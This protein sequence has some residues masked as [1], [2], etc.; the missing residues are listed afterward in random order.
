MFDKIFIIPPVRKLIV[1]NYV[2]SYEVLNQLLD[3][4]YKEHIQVNQLEQVLSLTRAWTL[5]RFVESGVLCIAPC[6][7]CHGKFVVHS[8]EI[9]S[10]HVCGLCNVPSRA[11]KTKK[12]AL[13][14]F[15]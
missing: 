14:E 10:N 3:K 4:L 8:L 1:Q 9:H 7:S 12:A 6:V 15:H 13:A 5:I 11:G 2:N